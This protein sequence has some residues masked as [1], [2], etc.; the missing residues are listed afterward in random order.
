MFCTGA[1]TARGEHIDCA[2]KEWPCTREPTLVTTDASDVALGDAFGCALG[3]DRGVRCW[4]AND[5]G[6]LGAGDTVASATPRPVID[7]TSAPI[8][9]VR[10]LVAGDAHACALLEDGAVLCWG[11]DQP[12]TQSSRAAAPERTFATRLTLP[13]PAVDVSDRCVVLEDGEMRCW[14]ERPDRGSSKAPVRV[15]VC[16]ATRLIGGG[17]AL[18]PRGVV[19][20][21]R[22]RRPLGP[23]MEGPQLTS[24]SAYGA[25][26]CGVDARNHVRCR[27]LDDAAPEI[28]DTLLAV[29]LP[30]PTAACPADPLDVAPPPRGASPLYL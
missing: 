16:D 5:H 28:G 8:A 15:G 2:A 23:A 18:G 19:C 24:A 7:A 11:Y 30:Q 22:D 12:D 21:G 10:K 25:R 6:Q 14:G 13:K 1:W 26:L 27:R 17:C 9:G 29:L 20:I 3:V 4:G